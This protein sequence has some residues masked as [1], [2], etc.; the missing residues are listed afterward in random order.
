[1][2]TFFY[3]RYHYI[4]TNLPRLY[5][6]LLA[7]PRPGVRVVDV[8]RAGESAVAQAAAG[9]R[10]VVIDGSIIS[11]SLLPNVN[12]DLLFHV[13]GYERRGRDYYG[14]IFDRLLEAPAALAFMAF[15]DLHDTR[16]APIFDRLSARGSAL[17]WLFEKRPLSPSQVPERY[18]DPWMAEAG[19]LT[20]HWDEMARR[21]PVRI[22]SWFAL[23]PEE[24][25]RPRARPRWDV[26][27]PG[28]PYHTRQLAREAVRAE[29]LSEAPFR[30]TSRAL[31][32]A[33]KAAARLP[34]REAASRRMIALSVAAQR[35]LV[36]RS[37]TAFVCG[38]GARYPVR[39]F[40][41]VPGAGVP[42]LAD[43]C[44]GFADFG[45]TDGVNA[46][47]CAPEDAG[48][49]ARRLLNDGALRDR[50][51]TAA[52]ETVSRLHSMRKRADDVVECLRRLGEG[53]LRNAQFVDGRFEITG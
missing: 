17:L 50:L 25:E 34:W 33:G 11:A 28:A 12:Y 2:I 14:A 37:R 8:T 1:M 13:A 9:S 4:N 3:A 16:A 38:S 35:A 47:V 44:L 43:P 20:A 32:L 21:F 22:E 45:F 53:K 6:H 27:I 30:Q 24:M 31:A 48:T 51:A 19:D 29:R 36:S 49:A 26:C 41:E 39:K 10:V 23:A 46:L 18:R 42:M 40:L 7:V 5:D 52:W 15:G